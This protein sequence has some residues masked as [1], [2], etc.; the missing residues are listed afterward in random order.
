MPSNQYPM[1]NNYFGGYTVNPNTG[2][3]VQNASSNS[4]SSTSTPSFSYQRGL[5]NNTSQ[6]MQN[7]MDLFNNYNLSAAGP[8]NTNNLTQIGTGNTYT[9]GQGGMFLKN[10]SGQFLKA[11]PKT[12]LG[13][14]GGTWG[15]IGAIATFG[16]QAAGVLQAYKDYRLKK[17]IAD[18]NKDMAMKTY[19]A[20]VNKYNDYRRGRESFA[21]Q[22]AGESYA[23]ARAATKD[24]TYL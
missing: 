19:N 12:T 1:S 7:S 13:L 21:R 14:N 17:S 23:D 8:I 18:F 2:E 11:S 5:P 15:T 10:S 6:N 24:K 3:L 20:N 16:I 4:T 22:Y 9:N